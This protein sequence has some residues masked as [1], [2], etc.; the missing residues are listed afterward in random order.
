MSATTLLE[1]TCGSGAT[2]PSHVVSGTGVSPLATWPVGAAPVESAEGPLDPRQ[3]ATEK[4]RR[5][6]IAAERRA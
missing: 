1:V 2:P 5:P 4:H 3:A 6:L